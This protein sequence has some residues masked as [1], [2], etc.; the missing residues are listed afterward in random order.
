[1]VRE[2]RQEVEFYQISV[3]ECWGE[4]GHGFLLFVRHEGTAEV[5]VREQYGW[6]PCAVE[7]G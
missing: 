5:A 7:N 2:G 6:K 4:R 3:R 1:M